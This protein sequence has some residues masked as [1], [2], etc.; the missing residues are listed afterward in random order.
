MAI[1]SILVVEDDQEWQAYHK[2]NVEQYFHIEPIIV[3][4]LK[5]ALALVKSQRFGLYIT[6]G[7][8][9]LSKAEYDEYKHAWEEFTR[10]VRELHPEAKIILITAGRDLEDI[11]QRLG[12]DY[13]LK[14]EID[15]AG[16]AKKYLS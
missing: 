9:P 2:A 5:D 7:R 13:Q 15:W 12:V 10:R 6:D 11:A 1:K 8:Y 3:D 14:G 16:L 4:N